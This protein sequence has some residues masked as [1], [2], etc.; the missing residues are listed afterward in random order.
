MRPGR[1]CQTAAEASLGPFAFRIFPKVPWDRHPQV[2]R[3]GELASLCCCCCHRSN[4]VT[5]TTLPWP[6][7]ELRAQGENTKRGAVEKEAI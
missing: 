2:L 1:R 5:Q 6:K 3:E 7:R 4:T